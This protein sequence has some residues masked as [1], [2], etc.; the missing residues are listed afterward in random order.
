MLVV[1]DESAHAVV[2]SA[3][4][5]PSKLNLPGVR[6]GKSQLEGAAYNFANK[7]LFLVREEARELLRYDW[8]GVSEKLSGDPT[9]IS[10]PKWGS[11]NKGVEGVASLDGTHSPTGMPQLLLANE[12]KPREVWMLAGNGKGGAVNV[13][14]EKEVLTAAND[15]SAMTVDPR[16]GH[17]F[18]SSDES[19]TVVQVRLEKKGGELHGRLVQSFPL[20]D[21]KGK[22]LNRVEGLSFNERGD[23]FVLT[24]N[25]G[26]LRQLIRQS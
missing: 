11:S 1:G 26:V 25:D 4:G 8:D 17:L 18:I 5:K 14:L 16:T 22:S 23:L 10:L 6:S 21:E 12:G 13:K 2:I 9:V 20:R 15:F 3:E 19:A 24:E 7:Q